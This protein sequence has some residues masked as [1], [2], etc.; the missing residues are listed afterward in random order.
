MT[1]YNKRPFKGVGAACPYCPEGRVF[2]SAKMIL[3]HIGEYHKDK[4][5]MPLDEWLLKFHNVWTRKPKK[6][7]VRKYEPHNLLTYDTYK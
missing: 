1:P 6:K 3:W 7:I 2:A 4:R 5:K